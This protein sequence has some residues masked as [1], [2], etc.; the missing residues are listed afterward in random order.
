VPFLDLA[1]TLSPQR[2]EFHPV[3]HVGEWVVANGT[4]WTFDGSQQVC[5]AFP[6]EFNQ[7]MHAAAARAAEKG[8]ECEVHFL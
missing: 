4:G 8:I 6:D 2:V 1:E 3:R 7:T 5:E